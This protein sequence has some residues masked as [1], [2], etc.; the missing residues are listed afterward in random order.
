M[1]GRQRAIHGAGNEVIAI[2]GPG[3]IHHCVFEDPIGHHDGAVTV[4]SPD[5]EPG[6][7]TT[8]RDDASSCWSLYVAWRSSCIAQTL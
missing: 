5:G 2:G 3:Q 1:E 6:V 4:H 8:Q 7:L